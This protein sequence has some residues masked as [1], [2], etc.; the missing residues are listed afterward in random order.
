MQKRDLLNLHN[1]LSIIEGRQFTVKFSYFVAKNKVLLKSEFTALDEAR[2][3]S[4]EFTAF[5][6]KRGE[7]AQKMADKDDK[8][9]PKIENNNFIIIE[10]IDEFNKA[11]EKLRKKNE[12]VIEKQ[13]N[14]MKDFDSLL[15]ENAEFQGTKIDLDDIP[16]NIEPFILEVLITTELIVESEG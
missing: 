2:K 4:D 10:K 3:P 1:A 14:K 5:N 7:L 9:Q 16:D 8:G 11:L 15:N 13:E 6:T 12:E